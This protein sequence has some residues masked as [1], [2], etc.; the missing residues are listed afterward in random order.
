M[1]FPWMAAVGRVSDCARRVCSPVGHQRSNTALPTAWKQL[2][3]ERNR[4]GLRVE[5]GEARQTFLEEIGLARGSKEGVDVWNKD[6][7]RETGRD[8][9]AKLETPLLL[10]DVCVVLTSPK[11]RHVSQ[12]GEAGLTAAPSDPGM[13]I[14]FR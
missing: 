14:N 11:V 7:P 13:M 5:Y 8:P 6:T 10:G 9:Y 1:G 12:R 4:E 2:R 3:R